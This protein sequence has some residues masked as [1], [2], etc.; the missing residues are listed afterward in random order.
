MPSTTPGMIGAAPGEKNYK[1]AQ[2]CGTSRKTINRRIFSPEEK[3]GFNVS[4]SGPDS[5]NN[6]KKKVMKKKNHQAKKKRKKLVQKEH[7]DQKKREK[8]LVQKEQ[9]DQ[10]N[11]EKKLVQNEQEDQNKREKKLVQK[12]QENQKDS[13]PEEKEAA[14]KVSGLTLTALNTVKQAQEASV[15]QK[16][17]WKKRKLISAQLTGLKK[18]RQEYSQTKGKQEKEQLTAIL[19][20]VSKE[21]QTLQVEEKRSWDG[22]PYPEVSKRN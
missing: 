15:V 9:E 12:E 2:H 5:A 17:K 13:V 11:R 1:N 8:K 3:S 18:A 16:T 10:N 6:L 7:E 14:P 21:I 20:N 4:T 22:I 19:Q